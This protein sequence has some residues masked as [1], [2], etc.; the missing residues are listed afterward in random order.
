M[1]TLTWAHS[2]GHTHMDTLTW[3]HSHGHT[4][5]GTLTW[6]CTYLGVADTHQPRHAGAGVE[7]NAD[8]HRLPVVWHAD[9]MSMNVSV[10]QSGCHLFG[11]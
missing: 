5:M 2:H 8:R 11:R 10:D 7:A 9:L 3:A 1:G 4:H 6:V